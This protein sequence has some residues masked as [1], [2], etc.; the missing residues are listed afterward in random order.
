MPDNKPLRKDDP[1]PRRILVDLQMDF[2]SS[3]VLSQ[4]PENPGMTAQLRE[5]ADK[6]LITPFRISSYQKA[7]S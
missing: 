5:L 7:A 1:S 2:A 6:G 3:P 4:P